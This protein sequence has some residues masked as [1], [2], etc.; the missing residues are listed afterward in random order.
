MNDRLT[1]LERFLRTFILGGQITD[2]TNHT[3]IVKEKNNL[4][5]GYGVRKLRKKERRKKMER[6][7]GGG[8]YRAREAKTPC[9]P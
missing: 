5:I 2:S 3:L 9:S 7:N 8:F 1:E 4:N 6:W